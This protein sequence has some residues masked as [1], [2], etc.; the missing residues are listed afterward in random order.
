[1]AAA[2][3]GGGQARGGGADEQKTAAGGRFFEQFEQGVGGECVHRFQRVDEHGAAFALVAG[4]GERR[5]Q[6][7][8]LFD[9]NLAT[10]LFRRA[11]VL[12]RVGGFVGLLAFGDDAEKVGMVARR[13]Q[14][15]GGA[16]PAGVTVFLRLVAQDA[17]GE[18]L[19]KLALANTGGAD[20]QQGVRGG[21]VRRGQPLPQRVQPRQGAHGGQGQVFS[22]VGKRCCSRVAISASMS[23]GVRA[24]SSTAK[25]AA[26]RPARA[27]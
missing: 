9:D 15:T 18:R 6:L 14:P 11:C 13:V 23:A 1:M 16:L 2:E 22:H 17:G 8:D 24:A 26:S 5:L 20:E 19:G 4:A 25:R 21:G 7:A 10:G 12:L 27:R 3:D